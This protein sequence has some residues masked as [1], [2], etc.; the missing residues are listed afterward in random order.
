[1]L[2]L[3]SDH[4][5]P[6]TSTIGF[7]KLPLVEVGRGLSSWRQE[8]NGKVTRT[9]V[10]GSVREMLQRLEPLT[11]VIR[12]RELLVQTANPAWTAYFDC[13]A[14]G[15]DA[16]STLSV[17]TEKLRCEGV[18]AQSMPHTMDRRSDGNFGSVQFR[19]YGP[20]RAGSAY[21]RTVAATNDGG[22][23]V[24]DASGAPRSFE[25]TDKYSERAIRN[26]FT[27]AMLEQYCAA[28]GI[29]VFNEH[30]YRGPGLV[31]ESPQML[32]E[33]VRSGLRQPSEYTFETNQ[34]RLG[35]R[36]QEAALLQP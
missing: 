7:F 28:L 26:R 29:E 1:M 25:Q 27:S 5:A 35:I 13:S 22:K 23:W 19:M 31:V 10:S 9:E 34:K 4:F 3:M 17:L 32:S 24:F 8:L 21:V 16:D 15:T 12:P 30:F 11:L 18:L 20:E 2:T 36:P 14:N 6:T 33:K